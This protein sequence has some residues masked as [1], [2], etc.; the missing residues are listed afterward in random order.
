MPVQDIQTLSALGE[1]TTSYLMVQMNSS[2]RTP[3]KA[4]LVL[5]VLTVL[6]QNSSLK[7]NQLI[8]E[9]DL[10]T[11]REWVFTVICY[12]R[13]IMLQF[14]THG[15]M[16]DVIKEVMKINEGLKHWFSSFAIDASNRRDRPSCSYV[17]LT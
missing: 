15:N 5:V 1:K 13:T 9:K 6:C 11:A 8:A 3:H 16:Y 14:R 7:L 2:R 12:Q 4:K 10:E 17:N